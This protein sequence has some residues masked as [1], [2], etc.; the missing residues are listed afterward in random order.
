MLAGTVEVQFERP[1]LAYDEVNL[2]YGN[3]P[4]VAPAGHRHPCGAAG[5]PVAAGMGAV[6]A[7]IRTDVLNLA[8]AAVAV[9]SGF[10]HVKR[11]LDGG[12]VLD[13][14]ARDLTD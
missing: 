6:R 8:S 3:L 13:W 9:R 14:F 11:T 12:D 7:V 1:Y 2:S 4:V 5:V 10:V